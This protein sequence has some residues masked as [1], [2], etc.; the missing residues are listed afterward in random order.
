MDPGTY[1][2]TLTAQTADGQCHDTST[3]SVNVAW[4]AQCSLN[5]TLGSSAN[6][7]SGKLS[8]S[9]ELFST[10]GTGLATSMTLY[11]NSKDSQLCISRHRLEPQLR[12][13]PSSRTADGSVVLHEGNGKRKLY[14]LSN[15][16]YVSQPGDYSTLVKNS[17]GTFTITQKD[18]TKYYF[19]SG[20]SINSIVD[21]NGNSM[22]FAYTGGNL[23][24]ITDPAGHSTTLNYDAAKNITS[25]TDPTGNNYT[26]AYSGNTL[27][28]VTYP[29]GGSM[30]LYLR[31][32]CLHALQDRPARQHHHL[33]L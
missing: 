12:H 13:H 2:A 8:H 29:D 27:A 3:A 4:N 21:R 19:A 30:A 15:G 28:S 31:R 6:V 25:V 16:A 26:F 20:G 1:T 18:G 9:Q 7:A 23:T 32:Q 24:T 33:C 14:T 5:V 22:N 17:N 10:R 11:Y